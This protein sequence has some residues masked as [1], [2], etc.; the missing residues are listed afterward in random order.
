MKLFYSAP[1]LCAAL[2]SSSPA[3]AGKQ[4]FTLVNRTGYEISEVYVSPA[5][6]DNWEEDVMGDRVLEDQTSVPISFEG[7][8]GCVYDLK[9]VFSDGDDAHWTNF[10]LCTIS[11]IQ[12]FW[13]AKT[14]KATAKWE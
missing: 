8:K 5:K 1:V 3:F 6:A 4:D 13:N 11:K 9:V 10:D 2:L 7:G 12:I 14:Q